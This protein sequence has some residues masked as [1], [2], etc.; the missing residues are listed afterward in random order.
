[1]YNSVV[2][3]LWRIFSF[4]ALHA[5]SNQPEVWRTAVFL[6]FAKECQIMS[7]SLPSS[8]VELE[9]GKYAKTKSKGGNEFNAAIVL[10]FSDFLKLLE[11]FA[12]KVYPR[13]S[14]DNASKRLLLENV[15]L[16]A[17]RRVPSTSKYNL[18]DEEASKLVSETYGKCIQSIYSHYLDA[19]TKRRNQ[20]IAA[21][22][23]KH[24]DYMND[25][26]QNPTSSTVTQAVVAKHNAL[27]TTL[28]DIM[29]EQKDLIGYKEYIQFC[30]D[31]SLKS[32]ALLT[33]IQVGE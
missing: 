6:R 7:K 15:L 9:I 25:L 8:A 18:S 20:L 28:R 2:E 29:A 27:L 26:I 21:E 23:I 14:A 33:A 32:T 16:L 4:Y 1:M 22:K 31:Y 19:A 10:S 5:D 12:V 24:R 3:E 30:Q 13:D 11:I 17:N